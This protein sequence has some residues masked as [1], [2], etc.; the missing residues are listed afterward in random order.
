[1]A[2]IEAP[3]LLIDSKRIALLPEGNAVNGFLVGTSHYKDSGNQP[4]DFWI[5]Q[6]RAVKK[7]TG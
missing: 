7:K 3:S 5:V 4:R 6:A 2:M 1:M